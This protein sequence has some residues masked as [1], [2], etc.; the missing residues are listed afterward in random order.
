MRRDICDYIR[1]NPT[2]LIADTPIKDWVRWDSGTGTDSYTRRMS[3]GSAWGGG[4]EMAVCSK[5]KGVNVHV[6]REQR[7]G[8]DFER[9]GAF[10]HEDGPEK[11]RTIRIV[12]RGGVHYD[13]VEV[14]REPT[15]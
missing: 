9:I 13:A 7:G 8:R 1:K 11:R 10:D 14:S 15:S 3:G 4:M 2:A 6:Y 5:L 12:Y